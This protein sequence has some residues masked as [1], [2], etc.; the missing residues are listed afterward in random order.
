MK[1]W[2]VKEQDYFHTVEKIWDSCP[3]LQILLGAK[4]FEQL[5]TDVANLTFKTEVPEWAT[6]FIGKIDDGEHLIEKTQEIPK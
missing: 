6:H 1:S 2:I 3:H 5:M 4:L